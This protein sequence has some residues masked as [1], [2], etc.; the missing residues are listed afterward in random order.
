MRMNKNVV[1]AHERS[2]HFKSF[3]VCVLPFEQGRQLPK[4]M[5]EAEWW[6]GGNVVMFW[7]CGRWI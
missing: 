2:F 5:E 7:V 4:Y 6:V 1:I 3:I